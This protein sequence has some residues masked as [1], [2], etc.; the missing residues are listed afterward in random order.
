MVCRWIDTIAYVPTEPTMNI[1][2]VP[3]ITY[4]V[5]FILKPKLSDSIGFSNV[6]TTDTFHPITRYENIKI[7]II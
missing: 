4:E 6:S 2:N 5:Y 1:D 3:N 7:N